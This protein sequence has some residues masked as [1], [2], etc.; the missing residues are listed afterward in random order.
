MEAV[1]LVEQRPLSQMDRVVDT[2]VAP[3]K[4]FT[5]ILRSRSWWLPFLLSALCGYALTIGIQ[6]KVGW[7]QLAQNEIQ[8][9]PKLDAQ[10]ANE[11]SDQLAAQR[12]TMMYS[13]QGSFYGFPVVSLLSLCIIAL[14]LW[15]TMNFVFAGKAT[16]GETFCVLAYGYLLPSAVKALVTVVLLYVGGASESF[17]LENMLGTS[18]GYYLDTA[19]ALKTFLTSFDIFMLWSLVLVSIGM[20]IVARTKR[21]NGFIAVFGWW[22]VMVI[23]KTGFAAVSGS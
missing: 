12:K 10:M 23:V 19:G 3:S 6:Q 21:V 4:T 1:A 11:T 18:P 17:N 5:D 8:A 14:I 9:N 16:F 20:A 15:P 22:A 7:A 2:F 13:Y